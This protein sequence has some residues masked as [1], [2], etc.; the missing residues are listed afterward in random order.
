MMK[1]CEWLLYLVEGNSLRATVRMKGIHR[2]TIHL[3]IWPK[4]AQSI[5]IRCFAVWSASA[6][7]AMKFGLSSAAKLRTSLQTTKIRMGRHVDLGCDGRADQARSLLVR[8]NARWRGP[9][10]TLHTTWLDAG[11]S[12]HDGRPQG[13]SGR[14]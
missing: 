14:C 4:P 12:A 2:T 13:L 3:L 8:W 9:H 11:S 1:R 7:N 10:T 6:F 5:M